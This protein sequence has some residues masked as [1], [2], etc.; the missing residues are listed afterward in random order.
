M[1]RKVAV[2]P[3]REISACL[4]SPLRS[5]LQRGS[6]CLA[7]SSSGGEWEGRD[8]RT[9]ALRGRWQTH[10]LVGRL[11]AMGLAEDY[12]RAPSD[13]KVTRIRV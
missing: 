2:S 5:T 10:L 6:H 7:S 8:K 11:G 3:K 13:V 1:A 9:E 4:R 12:W